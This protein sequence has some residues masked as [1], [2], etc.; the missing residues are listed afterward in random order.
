MNSLMEFS[1]TLEEIYSQTL[2]ARKISRTHLHQL[3]LLSR[4]C[5]L[6][7]QQNRLIKRLFHAYRRGWIKV[8]D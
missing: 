7:P 3:Q 4:G 5:S 8:I 6:N 2:C 1:G